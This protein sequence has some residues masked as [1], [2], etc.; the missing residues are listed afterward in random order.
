MTAGKRRIQS[1]AR[2]LKCLRTLSGVM[3][4]TLEQAHSLITMF[5]EDRG[6]LGRK[7]RINNKG[8][9]EHLGRRSYHRVECAVTLYARILCHQRFSSLVLQRLNLVDQVRRG[10][11][12]SCLKTYTLHP[13]TSATPNT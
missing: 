1:E 13:Y 11:H 7:A 12:C 3:Y 10:P 5:A 4:L 6:V 9:W 8:D 2:A